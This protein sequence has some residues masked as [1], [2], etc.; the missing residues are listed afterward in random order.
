MV[1]FTPILFPK[2]YLLQKKLGSSNFSAKPEPNK[3]EIFFG[4]NFNKIFFKDS[5]LQ[6]LTIKTLLQYFLRLRLL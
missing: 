3:N 6:S 5:G 2:L 4:L 1:L